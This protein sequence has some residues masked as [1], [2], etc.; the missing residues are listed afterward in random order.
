MIKCILGLCY[1]KGCMKKGVNDINV[2]L[3]LDG[4]KSVSRKFRSCDKHTKKL[5][6]DLM[7]CN[8]GKQ[9]EQQ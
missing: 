5:I 9:E 3:D 7:K 2:G 1:H 8:K 6:G 4:G